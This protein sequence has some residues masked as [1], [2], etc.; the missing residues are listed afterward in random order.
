MGGTRSKTDT[1]E[2]KA[3]CRILLRKYRRS[4]RDFWENQFHQQALRTWCTHCEQ[5]DWPH[6]I[7]GTPCDCP[8]SCCI[9]STDVAI[10]HSSISRTTN[11]GLYSYGNR[12]QT[13]PKR[14]RFQT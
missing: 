11:S 9:L 4:T 5:P 12:I 1:C 6:R 3:S 2:T 10:P 8:F 7:L 13:L 14:Y